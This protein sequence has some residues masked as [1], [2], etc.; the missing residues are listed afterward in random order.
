MKKQEYLSSE[1]LLLLELI[2]KYAAHSQDKSSH[3]NKDNQ[4]TSLDQF[5][6]LVILI[7]GKLSLKLIESHKKLYSSQRSRE[8]IKIESKNKCKNV[9]NSKQQGRFIFKYIN[10]DY[11][12][13]LNT[14][15]KTASLSICFKLMPPYL[16]KGNLER[17][18]L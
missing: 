8:K 9:V 12:Y 1:K 6:I 4:N 3:I 7:C 16:N 2:P 5:P 18:P 14:P 13:N 15:N 17:N 10:H 11:Q